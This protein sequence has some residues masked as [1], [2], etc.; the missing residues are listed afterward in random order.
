MKPWVAE[1]GE[2]FFGGWARM[3]QVGLLSDYYYFI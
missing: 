1:N 3:A 2:T